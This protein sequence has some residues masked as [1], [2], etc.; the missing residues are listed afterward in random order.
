VGVQ[1]AYRW[2]S[3]LGVVRALQ[4]SESWQR[5]VIRKP[6]HRFPFHAGADHVA[7]EHDLCR[8]D[9]GACIRRLRFA[10]ASST[11]DIRP[12]SCPI[13]LIEAQPK[14]AATSSDT[15]LTTSQWFSPWS[16]RKRS[17]SERCTSELPR[18]RLR[19][20]HAHE[21][22]QRNQHVRQIER[23]ELERVLGLKFRLAEEFDPEDDDAGDP[24]DHGRV[25]DGR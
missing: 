18:K 17:A 15:R 16:R 23:E 8:E 14:S 25:D 21:Q 2:R 9:C 11:S 13:S 19:L 3:G 20:A 24:C 7:R 4:G 10:L 5:F 6:G 12:N 22:Q 1:V